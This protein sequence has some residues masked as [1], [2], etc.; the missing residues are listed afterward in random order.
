MEKNAREKQNSDK[1]PK[2]PLFMLPSA[3]ALDRKAPTSAKPVTE[4]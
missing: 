3:E 1:K 4:S 2:I